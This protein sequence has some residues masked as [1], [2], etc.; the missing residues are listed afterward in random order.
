MAPLDAHGRPQTVLLLGARSDIGEAIV[1][2]LVEGGARTVI[3]AGR[4]PVESQL[5]DLPV[6]VESLAFDATDTAGHDSFFAEV[7]D[8]HPTIDLVVVAFGVLHD[9]DEAERNPDRAVDMARVNYV[10]AA[11]AVLHVSKHMRQRGK[12]K[13][14]VLSSVAGIVPRRSNFAYGSSKAGIDFLARGLQQSLR[15]SGVD[16]LIVRPGFVRSAMTAHLRPVR[17]AVDPQAVGEAVVDAIAGRKRAV[18]VPPI[19]R[20][21]MLAVK[22]LP[23]RLVQRLGG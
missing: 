8:R 17:F 16:V 1:R 3:L 15:G 22:V 18:W 6:E 13:I 10:G 5:G 19:L 4:E 11:S 2:Q 7:F 23:S 20:W 14:V 12:G 21:V 9:Q